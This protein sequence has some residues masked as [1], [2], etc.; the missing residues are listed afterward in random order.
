MSNTIKWE[1]FGQKHID[2][3]LKTKDCNANIL[4]GAVRAGKT[5]DNC[6][7]FSLNLEYSQ[8]KIHLASGS[9][10]AN[11]KLNIG[12]CN[13][14]GLEYL[15]R[16]RCRWGKYKDNDALF[17]TTKS[18]EKIIIFAGGGLA[19]SYKKILGNSYGMWIATEINEHYD[20]EDSKISFVKV[21]FA[22]M[23]ASKTN[24]FFWDM[25]PSNP[26][27]KIYEWYIDLWAKQGLVGGYNYQHLNI[28]DNGAIT[29][30]RRLEI[31]LK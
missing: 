18:G 19:N 17:V 7:A 16:G 29:E 28:F 23:L 14:F 30:Q 9:T 1:A 12:E 6:I 25:N 3:I 26:N 10:L 21:A 11:A 31:I 13:G 4:E 20:D 5:I 22:R 15:F 8:D 27:A 2:Y 24:K